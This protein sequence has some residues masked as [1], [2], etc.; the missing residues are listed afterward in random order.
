MTSITPINSQYIQ[1]S[2]QKNQKE[3]KDYITQTNSVSEKD[4][5]ISAQT[6]ACITA[7]ASSLISTSKSQK[8][9]DKK[10]FF[11]N[12]H[13]LIDGV[14]LRNGRAINADNSLFS[15]YLQT[16]NNKNQQINLRYQDGFLISSSIDNKL[17]KEYKEINGISRDKGIQI[18]EFNDNGIKTSQRIIIFD[19]NGKVK[20]IYRDTNSSNDSY[21]NAITAT[22][23]GENGE[24]AA[25]IK[26]DSEGNLQQAQIFDKNGN[27]TKEIGLECALGDSR[28]GNDFIEKIYDENGNIKIIKKAKGNY[29]NAEQD[30][31]RALILSQHSLYEPDCIKYYDSNGE[32]TRMVVVTTTKERQRISIFEEDKEYSIEEFK[33][34]FKKDYGLTVM[35]DEN[36][37]L[38]NWDYDTKAI[39][40]NSETAER[41]P[42]QE[43]QSKILT[44][45]NKLDELYNIM[46]KEGMPYKTGRDGALTHIDIPNVIKQMKAFV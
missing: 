16:I 17:F 36:N 37:V 43:L 31:P 40:L 9:K 19:N 26:Y 25:K 39:K 13:K 44:T 28:S 30:D 14:K 10:Q 45:A 2:I 38:F 6:A 46:Q 12:E 8:T 21:K 7:L 22:E 29:Y 27:L 33:N 4:M 20:R 34:K 32:M 5:D 23:Y 3:K 24:I 1:K 35:D 15:G 18:S 42:K 11:N 41:I